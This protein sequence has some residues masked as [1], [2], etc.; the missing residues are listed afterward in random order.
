MMTCP[1]TWKRAERIV[2]RFF[3]AERAP[4]GSNNRPDRTSSDST[5]EKLYIEVKYR[6]RH[7]VWTLWNKVHEK[8]KREK[9]TPVLALADRT[10]RG[11]LLVVHELHFD[12][13]A[14]ERN[15]TI[16]NQPD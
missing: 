9:K 2:A 8:A 15:R 5:H 4:A 3:G 1:E 14:S 13:V 12:K 6:E 11:R 16:A 10:G 7:T